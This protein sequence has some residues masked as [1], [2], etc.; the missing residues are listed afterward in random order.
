M[1]NDLKWGE[2]REGSPDWDDDLDPIQFMD[3]EGSVITAFGGYVDACFYD[4]DEW[5]HPE[6]FRTED[7]VEVFFY[8]YP[9]WRIAKKEKR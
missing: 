7:G 2:W 6:G 8:D 1:T 9:R 5:P 3:E 4:D